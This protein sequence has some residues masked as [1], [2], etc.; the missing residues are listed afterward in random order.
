MKKFT[1]QQKQL[2]KSRVD[3]LNLCITQLDTSNPIDFICAMGGSISSL[4]TLISIL[5]KE[6]NQKYYCLYSINEK[7][8][9]YSGF[10]LN[11]FQ[12][13]KNDILTYIYQVE[14]DSI[15]NESFKNNLKLDGYKIFESDFPFSEDLLKLN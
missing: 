8:F 3:N 9:Y 1:E 6:L 12:L 14:P 11:N 2:L 10:N 5:E 7:K 4:N 13:F 15:D